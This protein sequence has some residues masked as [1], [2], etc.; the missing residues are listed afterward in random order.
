MVGSSKGTWEGIAVIGD[1]N[2]SW[3]PARKIWNQ[4]GYHITN[5]NNDGSIPV[6]QTPNWD[7][8][9]NFREGGSEVG[10]AGVPAAG[11]L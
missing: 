4:H 7:T 3:A 10:P 9:N 6:T 1:L 2:E 8:W 11:R 5:V